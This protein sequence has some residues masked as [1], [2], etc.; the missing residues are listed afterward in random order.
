MPGAWYA[1]FLVLVFLPANSFATTFPVTKTE[2]TND[3][4][5][6]PDCS[7]REA[8]D[9]SNTNPGADDVSVPAGTYLL[10]LG[11]L[12]VSD[13]VSVA[14]VGQADTIIDGNASGRVFDIQATSGVVEIAGVT[15]QNGILRCCNDDS[16][17]GAGS[18]C[19]PV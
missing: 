15:I 17:E 6:D 3:G 13:E 11:Q 18:P 12:V 2:D 5:C 19:D 4:V 7:L 14:G 8:V 1:L 9:A 10:T 16:P